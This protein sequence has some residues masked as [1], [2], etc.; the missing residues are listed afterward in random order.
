M[1]TS[2]RLRRRI[3]ATVVT[4]IVVVFWKS[5]L[6]VEGQG[7]AP[8]EQDGTGGGTMPD[9]IACMWKQC[10]PNCIC[11]QRYDDDCAKD[12][13]NYGW[14]PTQWADPHIWN[15]MRKPV[16][17]VCQ[18]ISKKRSV[19]FLHSFCA[20]DRVSRVFVHIDAT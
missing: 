4:W 10:T 7:V 19:V 13:G 18:Y 11:D 1:S 2:K 17:I 12:Y 16:S 6:S 3:S 9:F 8:N 14:I 20:R 15:F 5:F